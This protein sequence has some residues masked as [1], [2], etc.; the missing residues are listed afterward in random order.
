MA[1]PIKD[2]PT[3]R[4][5]GSSLQPLIDGVVVRYQA[6]VPDERGE[7]VEVYRP[8]WNVTDAPLVYIYQISIMPGVVKGWVVHH[9]QEDRLF[10]SSGRVRFVLFDARESSSTYKKVN[11]LTITDRNRALIVIPRGVYHAVQNVGANEAVCLNMPTRAYDHG[12]PDKHRLPLANDLIPF[13]FG[14]GR[15][16]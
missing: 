10:V 8:S 1:T 15:V 11:D 5:D 16:R 4:P 12:D 3:V 13:D 9:H 14:R 6:T 2:A 7:V